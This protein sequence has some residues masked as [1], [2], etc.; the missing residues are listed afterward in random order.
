[1]VTYLPVEIT[2]N[3]PGLSFVTFNGDLDEKVMIFEYALKLGKLV[4]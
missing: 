4:S 2:P 3:R 1:M